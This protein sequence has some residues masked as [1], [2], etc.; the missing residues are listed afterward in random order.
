[1]P[2]IVGVARDSKRRRACRRPRRP[3]RWRRWSRRRRRRSQHHRRGP[4]A[5][6]AAVWAHHGVRHDQG[7]EIAWQVAHGETPDNIKNHP[8][9]KGMNIPRTGRFGRIGTLTTKTLVISGEAG[10][11]TTPQ[12]RGAYLHAY[13]KLT[14]AD[15]GAVYMPA[16]ETG[17]PMNI[18]VARQAIHRDRHRRRQL[19]RGA[20]G[21]PG[22][23]ATGDTLVASRRV[24][25]RSGWRSKSRTSAQGEV[26]GA[27]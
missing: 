26:P 3:W 7:R 2:Y 24:S 15:A 13:D 17:T 10:F 19:P 4:A 23:A 18:H 16:G 11:V 9:L 25:C 22:P 27:S 6:Q 5:D 14:G 8:K 1:M 20:V 12:G 21:V